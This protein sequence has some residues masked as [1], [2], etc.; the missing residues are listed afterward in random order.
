MPEYLIPTTIGIGPE[1][2]E[3]VYSFEADEDGIYNTSVDEV[4]FQRVNIICCLT[5]ETI[6][7]LESKA[8]KWLDDKIASDKDEALLSRW[9]ED[10]R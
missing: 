8:S 5:H 6:L 9:D 2:V 7:D 3:L 10:Q 4:L 1:N